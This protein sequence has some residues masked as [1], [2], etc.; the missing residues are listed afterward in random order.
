MIASSGNDSFDFGANPGFVHLPSDA[1]GI[2]SISAT[3]PI[4]WGVSS[5]TNLDLPA[6][7]SNFGTNRISFAAPGGTDN[8][9]FVNPNQV[10]TV[11]PVVNYCFVFDLVFSTIPG[12]WAWAMGTSMAA[13]TPPAWPRSTSARLADRCRR[14]WS[15]RCCARLRTTRTA[16]AAATRTTATAA[17]TRLFLTRVSLANAVF[18]G[19]RG[20]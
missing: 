16:T 4:G 18:T 13:R 17:W 9:Y 19:G 3:A 5:A 2:L 7:Y 1:P 11:G 14:S 8:Y 12:G 20:L 15:K 6:W 10:C